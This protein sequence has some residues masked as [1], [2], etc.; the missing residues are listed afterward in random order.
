MSATTVNERL[1]GQWRFAPVH[2]AAEFSVKYV[3]AK[4]RGNFGD[5]DAS[6]ED[7]VLTGSA[8]VASIST[9]DQNLYPH[10]LSPDF[11]DAEQHPELTFRSTSIDIQGDNVELDGELTMKGTT[12]PIHATGTIEGPVE[13]AMGNTRL[14]FT[15][16]A[17]IDRTQFGLNW[18]APLPKGGPSLANDVVLTVEL[19][20]H[21]VS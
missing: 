13:D 17:T 18:N 3:V 8:K 6:L 16:E 4:F 21:K 20:F 14:G 11:F 1:A 9:K 19:E 7:G 12:R 2:S 15:L 10:L 5:L